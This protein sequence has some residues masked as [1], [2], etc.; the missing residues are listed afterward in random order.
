MAKWTILC[1]SLA[2]ICG[3]ATAAPSAPT[4]IKYYDEKTDA[5]PIVRRVRTPLRIVAEP[6]KS[7][8][9]I[10]YLNNEIDQAPVRQRLTP[11]RQQYSTQGIT[12]IQPVAPVDPVKLSLA[13]SPLRLIPLLPV[14]TR[15]IIENEVHQQQQQ[16]P[17]QQEPQYH[18]K[19]FGNTDYVDEYAE[20]LS[21]KVGDNEPTTTGHV[22]PVAPAV[23]YNYETSFGDTE[24]PKETKVPI[25]K[26]A[27]TISKSAYK[28]E[29]LKDGKLRIDEL[30][31]LDKYRL[32]SAE[33]SESDSDSS[34]SSSSEE[35][36]SSSSSSSSEEDS[37]EEDE[38]NEAG[39]E[40]S[41]EEEEEED[42][43][44][45][46]Q[47]QQHQLP[48]NYYS[49]V[50][51]N[52]VVKHQPAP[53]NDFR[54]NEKISTKKSGIVYSEK[55]YDQAKYTKLYEVRQRYRRDTSDKA[56]KVKEHDIEILP[57]PLALEQVN[58]AK[59]LKGQ[60]LIDYI[61]DVINNSTKYLPD[62]QNDNDNT[63]TSFLL[64]SAEI[65]NLFATHHH[66][67]DSLPEA[68]EKYPF[69]HVP[70]SAL[71]Y[72]E[73]PKNFPHSH[74]SYYSTKRRRFTCDD[75]K[76]EPTE[77]EFKPFDGSARYRRLRSLG[78]KINCLKKQ[79]FDESPL[80]NPL[81]GEKSFNDGGVDKTNQIKSKL[82]RS[83]VKK[84]DSP[85]VNV[86]DD[87]ISNIR[88][89]MVAEH[90]NTKERTNVE[91][92]KLKPKAP[93][94]ESSESQIVNLKENANTIFDI[95]KYLPS[96][97]FNP[98]QAF[99]YA[100]RYKKKN[101]QRKNL[102]QKK[103]AK[104]RTRQHDYTVFHTAKPEAIDFDQEESRNGFVHANSHSRFVERNRPYTSPHPQY[105]TTP[106]QTP[107]TYIPRLS[108]GYYP[109][110]VL[111][112]K[113]KRF[114]YEL[115]QN[116]H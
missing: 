57:V 90:A 16:Q 38:D 28:V 1:A 64:T 21:I 91:L 81:F 101:K 86:Y 108:S 70:K 63:Y 54:I 23:Y 88:S 37:S 40:N 112:A 78:S 77:D 93:D 92:L 9:S 51:N 27:A 13:A 41:D 85:S 73:H 47:Q 99:I 46:D 97:G 59:T 109:Y 67:N 104:L 25:A 111:A 26:K 96:S 89:A 83:S 42:E 80:D 45:G 5:A 34:S 48:I 62:S 39:K 44:K 32:K 98:D 43:K 18:Q 35:D 56:E 114:H 75:N 31:K 52:A 71:R 19:Y 10:T 72:A 58:I 69:L 103:K 66:T 53:Q 113:K 100:V 55:G 49:Q 60:A 12:R 79:H 20:P 29:G 33:S 3:L 76:I 68:S 61:Q 4:L 110:P 106:T 30:A 107:P 95:N 22:A 116:V 6:V 15:K 36:G 7:R 115:L 2:V 14:G 87:V 84:T 50:Y 8:G 24:W 11:V 105:L 65:N 94:S 17:Q 74:Q 82:A 102:A